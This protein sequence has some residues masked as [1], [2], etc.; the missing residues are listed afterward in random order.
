MVH[1]GA[2]LSMTGIHKQFGDVVALR[3][4]S[5][6]VDRGRILGFLGPNGAGKTTMM[7]MIFGLVHPDAGEVSWNGAPV[8]ADIRLRFGYMPE[9]RGLYPKMKIAGQLIHFARLS[10]LSK[11]DATDAVHHW[12]GVLGLGDRAD[13]KLDE[14]SHGNQQ[15]A[16][17][18]AALAPNPELLVLDE[19]F[20]GLD[21]IGVESLSDTLRELAESGVAIVFSSHQLDL[22]EDVCQ[23]VAIIADGRIVLS[24][25]LDEIKEQSTRRR[26]TVDVDGAPWIPDLAGVEIVQAQGRAHCIVPGDAPVAEI[27]AAAEAAGSVSRFAFEPPH[28]TDLYRVAV[29]P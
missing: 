25:G 17:L 6:S 19:P 11:A 15:R 10:G 7:R 18:A 5:L 29:G 1:T 26:L 3:G 14:L 9:E 27:L 12:L 28:L 20:A 21:P 8:D 16:Q 2:V 22:V 4:A 23:D 13:A 24:G